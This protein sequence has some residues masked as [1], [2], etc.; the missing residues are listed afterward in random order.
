MAREQAR[1]AVGVAPERRQSALAAGR[2]LV[3]PVTG[4]PVAVGLDV[5][6]L[7]DA[8]VD[9]VE[10]GLHGDPHVGAAA[11]QKRQC[12]ARAREARVQREVEGTV[13]EAPS[14]CGGGHSPAG[15]ERHGHER[16]AVE[17]MLIVVDRG[18]VSHERE[19]ALSHLPRH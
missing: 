4:A 15:V 10:R 1:A 9:V 5:L 14:E 17:Q 13:L 2:R 19:A 3:L 8:D 16:I 6:A 7:E 12:L 11:E 18:R